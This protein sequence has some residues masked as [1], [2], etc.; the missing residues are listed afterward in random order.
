VPVDG[1]TTIFEKMLASE[2]IDVH[3]NTDFFS[4]RERFLEEFPR[5]VYTGMVDQF[6]AYQFGELEYR[7]LRFESEVVN[8]NNVQ[9]NAVINYTDFETPY[10]RV[11]EWRH[12]DG[13]GDAKKTILTRKYPQNWDQTKEAYYPVNDQKNSELFRKYRKE[14]DKLDKVIFGG[15]LGNY[16]Y[17]DINQVFEV[18]L[19]AVNNEF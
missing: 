6:F 14:A 3:L 8:C 9:G 17:Y 4:D 12:F 13:Q 2:L 15:R 1:Y 16:Q 18:V 19:K 10:T 5:I 11:M 7:S